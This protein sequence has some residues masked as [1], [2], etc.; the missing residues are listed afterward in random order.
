MSWEDHQ[1]SLVEDWK[2]VI[3][4]FL[5]L[6]CE[7]RAWLIQRKLS[8]EGA[9]V[10]A[11]ALFFFP[12]TGEQSDSRLSVPVTSSLPKPGHAWRQ[13]ITEHISVHQKLGL[14]FILPLPDL[15]A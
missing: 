8:M 11:L 15:L 9:T 2:A 1:V 4:F 10:L 12:C 3:C 14:S 13:S 5:V 7:P 6:E